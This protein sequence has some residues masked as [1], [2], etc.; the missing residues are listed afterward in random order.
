[1]YFYRQIIYNIYYIIYIIYV[2]MLMQV[3]LY[4]MFVGVYAYLHK[5]DYFTT[6]FCVVKKISGHI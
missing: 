1:M 6:S 4:N 3:H 2:C 5:S